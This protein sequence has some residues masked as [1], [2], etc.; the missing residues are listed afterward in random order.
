MILGNTKGNRFVW[1]DAC[2]GWVKYRRRSDIV[3]SIAATA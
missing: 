2:I 3:A 1:Y